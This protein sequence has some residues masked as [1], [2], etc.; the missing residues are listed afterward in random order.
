MIEGAEKKDVYDVIIIGGGPAGYTAGLYAARDRLNTLLLESLSVMGQ[1][2]MTAHIENYPGMDSV[3]GF[4]LVQSFK[5]QASRFGLKTESATVSGISPVS[6]EEALWQVEGDGKIYFSR[7]II[8]AS[9]AR[10]KKLEIPGEIEFLSRGV[11]YCGTCDGAFFRD[12][13]IVV[14]GGGNTALEEALYLT[15]YGKSV[16][17]VHRR[18]RFRGGKLLQE[19]AFEH[20][21][22]SV[23]W[24]SV[25]T[26]IKGGD[27]VES[28]VL[29]NVKTRKSTQIECDGVF[30]FAGW[31]PN[32]D[33]VPEDIK[34]EKGALVTDKAMRTSLDG[35]FAAGDCCHKD[36]HQVVTA[37]GDGANAAHS[38]QLYVERLKG[39]A[40]E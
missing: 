5:D 20:E 27:S 18:D 2:V 31:I 13:D 9:G 3:S 24:D 11:S 8:V 12:K 36:F 7:S 21:K 19:R 17:I 33:F 40:Y 25:V 16:R 34:K 39:T 35:L 6:G 30:I 23:I 37:C 32:T 1:A 28:L 22:I 14:V 10:P 26:E 29:E 15:R 38:A 4:E